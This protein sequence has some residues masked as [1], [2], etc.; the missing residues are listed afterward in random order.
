M[1]SI[2]IFIA[3]SVR[4]ELSHREMFPPQIDFQGHFFIFI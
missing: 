4:N 1:K 3:I 2:F